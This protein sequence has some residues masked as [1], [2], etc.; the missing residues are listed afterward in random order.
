MKNKLIVI[1]CLKNYEW[2]NRQII[3]EIRSK[4]RSDLLLICGSKQSADFW[5]GYLKPGEQMIIVD[6]LAETSKPNLLPI[7]E[8]KKRIA[9]FEREMR[10]SFFS[11]ILQQSRGHFSQFVPYIVERRIG[12]ADYNSAVI[13]AARRIEQIDTIFSN[14]D[15]NFLYVRPGGFLSTLLIIR[16]EKIGVP[17]TFV[18]PSRYKS[19]FNWTCGPYSDGRYLSHHMRN[20]SDVSVDNYVIS[21]ANSDVKI[22]LKGLSRS[23]SLIPSLKTFAL[24]FINHLLHSLSQWK[25]FRLYKGLGLFAQLEL[26]FVQKWTLHWLSKNSTPKEVILKSQY[27]LFLLPVEP[28]FTVNS[29][30]RSFCDVKSLIW[31][32]AIRLPIDC[33]L[34]I[35]EHAKFGYRKMDFY[36]DLLRLPNVFLAGIN[37]PG[38][39]LVE[40]SSGVFSIA[41]T[42]PLEAGMFGIKSII[43]SDSVEYDRL[44]FVRRCVSMSSLAGDIREHFF[45][46]RCSKDDIVKE[47]KCYLMALESLSFTVNNSTVFGGSNDD[48]IDVPRVLKLLD[49][50]ISYQREKHNV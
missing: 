19:L 8:A 12:S 35:K 31:N 32:I 7:E 21:H 20:I 26:F 42:S 28:E 45:S 3:P 2:L 41:G 43:F 40:H 47:T 14:N 30:G 38:S 24:I 44:S 49:S 11:D 25:R 13:E 39:D 18:R 10:T 5:Q 36:E 50:C 6:E 33:H 4:Y 37:I 15:I 48:L 46:E 29:L 27:F 9:N 23:H 17:V 16:A 34:V 22:K 1:E